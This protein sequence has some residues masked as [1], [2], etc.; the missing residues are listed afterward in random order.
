MYSILERQTKAKGHFENV[1]H[2][3]NF[4]SHFSKK[5]K[6]SSYKQFNNLDARIHKKNQYE[7]VKKLR[8]MKIVHGCFQRLKETK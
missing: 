8:N 7:N 2:A 1:L 3:N 6:S 4:I 5:K